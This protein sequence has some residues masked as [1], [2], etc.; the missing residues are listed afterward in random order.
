M[1]RL[2][3]E[4]DTYDDTFT[5]LTKGINLEVFEWVIEN[6]EDKDTS[7]LEVGC[8]TGKLSANIAKSKRNVIA[9]DQ[10]IDMINIAMSKYPTD[11]EG[12]LLYQ[13]GS[14]KSLP[15]EDKTQ[16]VII[17]TFMLS[18]LRPLEQ[19]ILLRNAWKA[20][21]NEGKLIIAAEFV[22]L[23]IWRLSFNVKRWIYR[24]KLRRLYTPILSTGCFM[25]NLVIFS[26][27][28]TKP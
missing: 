3:E 11:I 25:E 7:I 4:P 20:L 19:Q 6:L 2:E 1:K 18:E 5:N 16:D 9:I 27:N 22:P 28:D 10:N 14:F 21:K 8:G 24:R 17:S 26:T 13:L 12:T 15:V 23:G